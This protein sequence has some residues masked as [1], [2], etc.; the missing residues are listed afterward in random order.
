M[1]HNRRLVRDGRVSA[2]WENPDRRPTQPID[3]TVG[4]LR[5]EDLSGKPRAFAV[6]YACHPVALMGAGVIS[7]DFPGA[8]VDHIEQELG[9][10]CLAMFLQ[11]ASRSSNHA[12]GVS[13]SRGFA[14]P[15]EP[16]GPRSG[17]RNCWP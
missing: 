9:V 3:P 14:K 16:I 17:S 13:K 10:D 4:V 8:M 2:L 6:H 11:G 7:R 5:V 15:F 12:T 1:A